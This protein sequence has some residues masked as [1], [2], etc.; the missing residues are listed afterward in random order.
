VEKTGRS[1]P[2]WRRQESWRWE[3]KKVVDQEACLTARQ[4]EVLQLLVEGKVM[5]EL[6]SILNVEL[7]T[8]TYHKYRI[9]ETLGARN[10]AE[11]VR[12]AIK[13]HM[14]AA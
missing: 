11:L 4:R 9:M 12:Y 5:K 13:T 3:D 7:T 6:G 8:V 2:S 14:I 1:E 10:N